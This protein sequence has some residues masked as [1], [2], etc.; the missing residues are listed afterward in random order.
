MRNGDPQTL[1]ETIDAPQRSIP[2]PTPQDGAKVSMRPNDAAV[3]TARP[4]SPVRPIPLVL[5]GI[6]I[7]VTTEQAE[8]LRRQLGEP[9][10]G[11]AGSQEEMLTPGEAAPVMRHSAKSVRKLCCLPKDDPRYLRHLRKGPK[12]LIRRADIAEWIAGQIGGN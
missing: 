4:R 1:F 2:V 3:L 12:I 6:R 9:F 5:G 7:E 11:V 8:E 10:D